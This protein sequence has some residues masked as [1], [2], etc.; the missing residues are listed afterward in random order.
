MK[1]AKALRISSTSHPFLQLGEFES[2]AFVGAGGKTTAMFQLTRELQPP[3][4]VSA[5]THLGVWQIPLA[6]EHIIAKTPDDL[7][8]FS[9]R[10]VT[11]VTGELEGNRTKGLG[12]DAIHWLHEEAQKHSIPLLIEAD[13]SRQK[14]LKAP[15]EH[16]PPIPDFVH[17]VVVVAGL[18]GLGRQ[19]DAETVHRPEIFARLSGLQLGETISRRGAYPRANPSRRR[20]EKY[21]TC[22]TPCGIAQSGRYTR[23]AGAGGRDCEG[24]AA[25][26]SLCC[27]CQ[28]E[29]RKYLC[30]AVQHAHQKGIIHRDLKPTNIL[31]ALYDGQAVPK[32]I[33]FGVAKA[34]GQSLTEKTL[35]TE[36]GQVIGT[37]EYMSPEQAERNQLDIDTRSD[38]YS[39]GV[40]LYELLVG[41]TPFDR[42]RLRSAAFHEILRI[43]GREDPPRPSTRLS[44]SQSL[45]SIAANR[46]LEPV[47]LAG[48]IR[49]D[50]D[51]IVMKALE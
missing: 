12:T 22:R 1:L 51:W 13:G 28:F 18:S 43:L 35:F 16:E 36:F 29:R 42:G 19:L 50:L 15:G 39:L 7:Q 4:I 2:I 32:V 30:Q 23:F 40:I 11:L 10:G 27:C 33:D 44:G 24:S 38:I 31:V 48:T 8:N 25:S 3:V 5:T 14:P 45:P 41:E 37:L 34:T 17:L 49:G 9:P 6:D 20:S 47:R 26:L 46:R 21:S